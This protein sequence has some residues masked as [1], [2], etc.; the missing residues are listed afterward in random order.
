MTVIK[1]IDKSV[2]NKSKRVP[3]GDIKFKLT[4]NDEQ[5]HAKHVILNAPITV[6]RGQAGSGKTLLACAVALDLYFKREIEKIVICRPA[7]SKEDIGFLPGSADDK[8]APYLQPVVDNFYKLYDKEAIDKLIKEGAIQ[9]LPFAF[10]RGHTFTDSFIIVDEA[11][12]L[13][14][15]MME[16]VIG[17]LGL[18]SKLVICGDISQIDLKQKKDSGFIF[19]NTIEKEV[20]GFKIVELKHNHRHPIVEQILSVYK[21]YE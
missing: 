14:S 5:K 11:Q 6:L 19:L 8:L 12:N 1:P 3:K 7:I 2:P 15:N 16:L 10:M 18:G 17:R 21:K 13:Y 9:I 4:L 20:E